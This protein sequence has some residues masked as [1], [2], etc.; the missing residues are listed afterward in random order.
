[1]PVVQ[2]DDLTGVNQQLQTE[3]HEAE[4][5]KERLKQEVYCSVQCMAVKDHETQQLMKVSENA[6]VRI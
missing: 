5:T 3:L 2:M 4:A 6:T 1:M